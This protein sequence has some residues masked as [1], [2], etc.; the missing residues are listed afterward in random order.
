LVAIDEAHCIS[1][2]GH[3]F[4]T[5]Y[6]R[7]PAII[8]ALGSPPVLAVTATATEAV[9]AEICRLLQ[10]EPAD[11]VAQSINR[12]NIAY[13]VIPVQSE[14]E[15]RESMISALKAL[16]GAGIVYCRTRQTVD[17]L[18]AACH[19][20][21]LNKVHGY[22]GGMSAMERVLVQEQFLRGDLDVIIATNAF[23]M[24]IDKPDI[25]FV[26]HYH[27]PASIEEYA[28]EVGRIGRDG[29]PGYAGLYYDEEDLYIHQHLMQKEYPDE[30]EIRRFVQMI[31]TWPDAEISRSQL[32]AGLDISEDRAQLLF[33]YAEQAGLADDVV[34]T[35]SGYRFR[36][37][38][39]AHPQIAAEISEKIIRAKAAK[40]AK[41]SQMLDWLKQP[42][43]LREAL[44]SYFGE[45]EEKRYDLHCCAR[46]GL[47]RAD[48]ERVAA[49]EQAPEEKEWDLQQ[50]LRKLLPKEEAAEGGRTGGRPLAADGRTHTAP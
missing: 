47:R 31:A 35:R 8:A 6:L 40:L 16:R 30:A 42:Q 46:C 26:L 10:I 32:A 20:A 7:L 11:I 9:Q 28:Q 21:G 19:L 18:V 12:P 2:W 27:F 5:D 23:G 1:Q 33:F 43:C 36:R 41:L 34:L 39:D 37:K 14:L 3:D 38:A 22:H 29:Q 49:E 44:S 25:R 15:K 45:S 24:G 17:Q 13:D 50:A 48:Y 4:R